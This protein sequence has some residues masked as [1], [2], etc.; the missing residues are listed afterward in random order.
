MATSQPA[1]IEVLCPSEGRQLAANKLSDRGILRGKRATLECG[2]PHGMHGGYPAD[3]TG[4]SQDPQDSPRDPAAPVSV[5]DQ[6]VCR[7][8]RR[9][10][11]E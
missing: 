2:A 3:N 5:G 11:R 1:S 9:Y 10:S 7:P 4:G 8:L 6:A